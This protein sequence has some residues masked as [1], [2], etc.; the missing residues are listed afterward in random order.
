VSASTILEV[1]AL[2]KAFGGVKAVDDCTFKVPEGS[3]V[4]LIGPNGAG[5]ST[6]IDMVSGFGRPDEGSVRFD[7]K[8]VLNRPPHWIS[9]LG[10]IRTFQSPR[11]WGSLTV[12]DNVMLGMR[13]FGR[14]SILR[15]L[16]ARRSVRRGEDADLVRVEEILEQF[17]LADLRYDRAETLSGG[18]KRLV[19]FARV[20]AA[21]PRL[22]ILD[23]PMGGVNPVLGERM[24]QAIKQFVTRG[25]T[26]VI[27]E[28]N[29]KFIEETCDQVV[30]MDLGHVIAQGPYRTLRDDERVVSAY[31][32]SAE[33]HV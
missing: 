24:S 23:E 16:F 17:N 29:M 19:E 10:L 12:L 11:E 32:G 7:G 8:E 33:D 9:R 18:Q 15:N 30:V 3:V 26:V 2:T 6:T 1:T 22:V 25:S 21:E 31:L 20:A 4:G 27:V 28:H 13:A 5:K 14:E